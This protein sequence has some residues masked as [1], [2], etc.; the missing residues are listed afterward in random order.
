MEKSHIKEF[1]KQVQL[2]KELNDSQLDAICDKVKLENYSTKNFLFSEN[3]I[4]KNL[5]LIYEGEVELFKRTPYGTEKR[6]SIFSKY[7]FL[8]EGALMDDSPHSTSARATKDSKIFILTSDSFKELMKEQNETALAILSSIGKVISRRISAAN[9][10]VINIAAQYQSGRT[11]SEHDLLGDR[12]VPHEYYYGVQ[13]LRALENFNISGVTLNFYPLLI[14]ALAMV[15][16][17]AALAN[18]DL[19]LL[20]KEITDAIVKACDEISGGRLHSH[21]VVDMIQGGAGTST[22]MN[23]NEVIANRA[24]E[25]LGFEKGD[26]E[27]CHPNNHV[28]LSQSTN[29]AYPTSVKIALVN[30]NKKLIEVLQEL[31]SSFKNKAKEFSHIIKMGRTQLQDAV[32]MTLGQEFE[33]YA[34]MLNEEVQRLEQNAKLFLEVNMGATA[35]GTGINSHP[36]YSEKVIIHLNDVTGLSIVLAENLVEATQDTGSFIMYSS[37]VKRLAVKLSKISNDLRLLSSGPRTGIHEINLP[38]MQPGSSIMPGKVNPVIPEVVS[39][40]AFKVIGND[41]AVTMAAEGG[42]LELNVFEPVIVQSLFESIEMLKNGMMTLKE[43]CIDGITANE[44]RCRELVEGSIGIVT[45]L[46][47]ALGYETCTK[48]AKE[49]LDSNR[50]VYELVLEKKLLSKAELDDLLKP[51][52]M[53]KPR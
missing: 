36:D 30:S 41:L 10:R 47:P 44:D 52:N 20:S 39:Q 24:L 49:A 25:I 1:L 8:G 51:E 37:A 29:D 32:P 45:A 23:A 12:D 46:N 9:T 31:I 33:A 19:G 11:R 42:Q 38:P 34:V 6:L 28:N 13:T 48:L 5:F 21:F 22:N 26:Y 3:N 18:C 17:A 40:I 16:K 27:H 53:I 7:D 50:G 4:R 2:F 35:I 43:K 14:E 15:K